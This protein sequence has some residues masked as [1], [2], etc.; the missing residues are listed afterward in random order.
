MRLGTWN[1]EGGR[2]AR[3]VRACSLR[4]QVPCR[5]MHFGDD[6]IVRINARNCQH[7]WRTGLG[8]CRQV[9]VVTYAARSLSSADVV[10]GIVHEV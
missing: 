1:L 7:R 3:H 10:D 5:P 4:A 9:V 2:S 6:A 8:V